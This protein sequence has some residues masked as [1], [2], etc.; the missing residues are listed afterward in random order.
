[1]REGGRE[2][3]TC[4]VDKG[5]G[6]VGSRRSLDGRKRLAV[7]GVQTDLGREGGREG[8]EDQYAYTRDDSET[9]P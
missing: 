2:G 4:P 5:R 1:V 6:P 7:E 9:Q 3:G 8:G